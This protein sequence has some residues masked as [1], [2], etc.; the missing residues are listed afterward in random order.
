MAAS[1]TQF[2]YDSKGELTQITDPRNNITTLTY[3]PVGLIATIKDAQNNITTYQ[4]D[5]RGNRTGGWPT[6]SSK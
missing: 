6:L 3:T 4:Y 1:V 2:Q 5:T